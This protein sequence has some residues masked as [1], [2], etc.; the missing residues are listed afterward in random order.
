MSK[1]GHKAA[2]TVLS[3]VRPCVAMRLLAQV[4][5]RGAGLATEVCHA[6]LCRMLV[7]PLMAQLPSRHDPSL[8]WFSS[9][10]D[11]LQLWPPTSLPPGEPCTHT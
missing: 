9:V 1:L 8:K 7:T 10:T 3:V 11:K 2:L 4:L 5:A 6:R